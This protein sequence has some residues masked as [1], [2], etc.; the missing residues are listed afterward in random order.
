VNSGSDISFINAKFAVKAHCI[1]STVPEIQVAKANGKP[2][3]SQSACLS[4]PYIIQGHTFT[5]NFRLL[6]VQGYDIILGADWIYKH[7]PVGLNMQTRQFSITKDGNKL[8][9]FFD[10]SF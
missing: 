8:I 3:T 1:L 10:E 9:T 4:C 6:E 5:T 2:M 7:R